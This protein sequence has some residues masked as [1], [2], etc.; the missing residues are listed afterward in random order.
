MSNSCSNQCFSV[1]F[2][3]P[4]SGP[5]FI[6]TGSGS[7]QQLAKKWRKIWISTVL[8]LWK[9]ISI[10]ILWSFFCWHLEGNKRKEQDPHPEPYLHPDQYQNV[11]DPKYLQSTSRFLARWHLGRSKKLTPWSEQKNYDSRFAASW[12]CSLHGVISSNTGIQRGNKKLFFNF[13][14]LYLNLRI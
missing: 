8:W 11:T 12:K 7:F 4:G 14:F 1:C 5:W 13:G 3:S 2:G 6:Y 9:R 10:K